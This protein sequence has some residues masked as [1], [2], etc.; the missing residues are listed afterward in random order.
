MFYGTVIMK[1]DFAVGSGIPL[2]LWEVMVGGER[3][4]EEYD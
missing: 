1:R 4:K 3:R 2:T